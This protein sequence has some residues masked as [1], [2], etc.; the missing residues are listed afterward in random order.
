[1]LGGSATLE[2]LSWVETGL[3]LKNSVAH[4]VNNHKAQSNPVFVSKYKF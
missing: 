3:V 1:M 4:R 2:K